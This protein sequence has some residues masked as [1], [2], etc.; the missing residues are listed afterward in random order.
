MV[1]ATH[2]ANLDELSLAARVQKWQGCQL[3]GHSRG[4][5]DVVSE[6]LAPA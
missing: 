6:E 1:E 5:S 3:I 2:M 4:C